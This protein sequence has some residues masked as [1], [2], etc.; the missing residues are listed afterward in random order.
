MAKQNDKNV[1]RITQVIGS[2]LDAEF[3]DDRLP[4]LY[5]A[6]KVQVER[7]VLGA[8]ET[9]TLWCEVALHLG[10]GHVRAV[11]LGS[12]DGLIRGMAIE[13]TG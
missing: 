1:G 7:K 13:D 10:G 9:E 4:S 11:A 8:T 2:T 6:L 5:N 12:T 3:D